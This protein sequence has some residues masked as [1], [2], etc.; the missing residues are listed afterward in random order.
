MG[1]ADHGRVREGLQRRTETPANVP[2]S[3]NSRPKKLATPKNSWE[4][5]QSA[6]FSVFCNSGHNGMVKNIQK[7]LWELL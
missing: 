3:G 1:D 7:L 2:K 5:P 6:V 4:N